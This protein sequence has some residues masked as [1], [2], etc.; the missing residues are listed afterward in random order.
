MRTRL[1]DML[2]PEHPLIMAP[3][4]LVSNTAK[5]NKGLR[6]SVA[7]CFPALNYRTLEA[8]LAACRE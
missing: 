6:Y 3:I 7:G 2:H 1:T 4:F 5:V 8:L